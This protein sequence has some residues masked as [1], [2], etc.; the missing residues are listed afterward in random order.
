MSDATIAVICGSTKNRKQ[1]TELNK[2]LTLD[3]KIVLAPGVFAHDGD[4][5]T[6]EQK[7]KLD[8]LHLKKIDLADEVHVVVV[9]GYIGSSTSAEIDYAK[10]M[11]KPI[12]FHHDISVQHGVELHERNWAGDVAMSFRS[13]DLQFA[14]DLDH[15]TMNVVFGNFTTRLPVLQVDL[16]A[17]WWKRAAA[18]LKEQAK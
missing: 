15:L 8:A 2:K 9:G 3:G 17:R 6:D 10:K 1:M 18:Y 7:T 11:G 14:L 4:E 5:I 13:G 16:L 12:T